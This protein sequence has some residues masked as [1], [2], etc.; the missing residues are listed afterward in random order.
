MDVK[1]AFLNGDLNEEIYMDQ[2]EG[3]I[4]PG[5][6]NKVCKLNKS[7]YGL[8]QAPKQWHEKFDQC[9]LTNGFRSNES[10]KCIYYKSF[11]DSH[12][13]ICLYVDDLLIFGTNMQVIEVTKALLKSNFEMKDLGEANVILGMKI[14]KNSEGIF[15][16]QSH[17][18]EK[19]FKK[20]NYFDCKPVCT[21]FDSHVCLFPTKN[22]SDVINQ[23]EYAS[24][25][26][27]L[28]YATDCTRPDIAYAVGVLSRFTSKPN[29]THWNA[30]HRIMRYLKRTLD[31]GLFY[32][33]YPAVLEGFSDA[34]WSSQSSDS[35]SNTGYLFTLGGGAICWRSKKQHIIAKSTMEAE[36][37]ALASACEEAGWLRDLLSE[38]PMW[39]KPIP[40]VLIHCDS[41]A[42][43]GRVHNKYYNGKS[44]SIRRKHSTVR[45]YLNNGSLTID[46]V[47]SGDN[48]A[49][50]LTKALARE[51]IWK[52]SREIGL[53]PK[54]VKATYEDTTT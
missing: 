2:P 52:A 20:Y 12:V 25:I 45:S 27:S 47:R 19:I 38:I 16:D 37:I 1:T 13:I 36:L 15:I 17:Y 8:K 30:I 9:V 4:Q 14:T 42:A 24:I 39:N 28:R 49:D 26:G 41:T 53:K 22:D 46:F 35:L 34:D 44:R 21:P 50:Q 51:K 31:Y 6:E 43:I 40:P 32:K 3:F 48:L 54:N 11:G 5:L 23:K 33:K 18:I 7:L 29:F 10:D